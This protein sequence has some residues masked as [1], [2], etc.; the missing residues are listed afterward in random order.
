MV[1]PQRTTQGWR[2][3][4]CN[5]DVGAGGH[6]SVSLDDLGECEGSAETLE[7]STETNAAA[8]DFWR[9]QRQP[10]VLRGP[11]ERFEGDQVLLSTTFSEANPVNCRV[12]VRHTCVPAGVSL[13]GAVPSIRRLGQ[14][15]QLLCN[16]YAVPDVCFF[17]M[18]VCWHAAYGGC[19]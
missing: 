15:S 5:S 1:C 4:G 8:R 3:D 6:T 17:S 13:S 7:E 14:V 12:V 9:A 19:R 18:G 16:R 2:K 11:L 10:W